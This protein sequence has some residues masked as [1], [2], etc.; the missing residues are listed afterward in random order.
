VNIFNWLII[1]STIGTVIFA[2]AVFLL[3]SFKSKNEKNSL[4]EEEE[5]LVELMGKVRIFVDSKMELLEKKTEEVRR[6]LKELNEQY[7]TFSALLIDK[8]SGRTIN[9]T[10]KDASNVSNDASDV[11]PS[12][13]NIGSRQFYEQEDQ[14]VKEKSLSESE[15]ASLEEKIFDMFLN[16]MDPVEIAKNMKIGVG[17]VS[18]IIDLMK[19][20]HR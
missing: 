3:Q 15:P 10:P 19:R 18:L 13:E 2:W 4:D 5:R 8:N 1:F 17:E 14:E 6:L 20:Q 7:I 12:P 9:S 11:F 16:G